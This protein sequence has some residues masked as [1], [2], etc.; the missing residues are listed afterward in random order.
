MSDSAIVP[1]IYVSKQSCI[2]VQDN[3]VNSELMFTML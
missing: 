3:Y 2:F 1:S